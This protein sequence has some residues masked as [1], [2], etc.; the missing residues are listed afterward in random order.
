VTSSEFRQSSDPLRSYGRRKGR[1]LT[2][3]RNVLIDTLLPKLLITLPIITD[4]QPLTTWFEIGFGSGEH[5]VEQAT[6]HPA[7]NFIG[8]EP[9]INGLANLLTAIDRKKLTNIKLYDGDARLLMDQLPDNSIERLFVLF[10]DPWPKARHNKRRIIS[11]ASLE[12]FY[13]KIKPGGILRLAT[14]H[15]DYCT[16]MLEHLLAFD[17]FTWTAK[18]KADWKTQPEDWVKTRYQLKAEAEGRPSVFMDWVKN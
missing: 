4:P 11:G 3:H 15:E 6:N 13:Q 8:C 9:Y 1:K 10:P 12:L 18:S 2:E 16:W 17:K 14:D 7:I 5:L